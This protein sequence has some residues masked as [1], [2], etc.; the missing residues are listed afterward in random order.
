MLKVIRR[1]KLV[2]LNVDHILDNG[3]PDIAGIILRDSSGRSTGRHDDIVRWLDQFH[4][5]RDGPSIPKIPDSPTTRHCETGEQQMARIAKSTEEAINANVKECFETLTKFFRE[6]GAELGRCGDNQNWT[7]AQTAIHFMKL[8]QDMR[9]SIHPEQPRNP[10]RER[11]VVGT[12]VYNVHKTQEDRMREIAREEMA[13]VDKATAKAKLLEQA[14]HDLTG[15]GTMTGH[16]WANYT[17]TRIHDPDGW[18]N[19]TQVTLDT[20]ISYRNY[21]DRLGKSSCVHIGAQDLVA[22]EYVAKDN[23]AFQERLKNTHAAH[24]E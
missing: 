5:H 19:D 15:G 3:K 10:I 9:K 12:E 1:D 6:E 21:L 14:I 7:P 2:A 11:F 8:Y 20:Y 24:F 23:A 17:G 16:G 13:K 22:L 18:R 4:S